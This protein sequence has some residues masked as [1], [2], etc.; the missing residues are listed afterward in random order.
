MTLFQKL[1]NKVLI[2]IR[3]KNHYSMHY[4]MWNYIVVH[5]LNDSDELLNDTDYISKLKKMFLELNNCGD[6]YRNCFLCELY[7][8]TQEKGCAGCPIHDMYV[9][10]CT[11]VESLSNIVYD[12]KNKRGKRIKAAK[13]IRDCVLRKGGK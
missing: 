10:C 4:K 11:S 1:H 6:I 3:R 2:C 13:M 7:F 9:V 5:L 8:G 12:I